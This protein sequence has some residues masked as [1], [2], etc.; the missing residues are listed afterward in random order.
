MNQIPLSD[1]IPKLSF[2][3]C[4]R[5]SEINYLEVCVGS[6]AA[7]R[8]IVEDYEKSFERKGI[9]HIRII[10]HF[11]NDFNIFALVS[12]VHERNLGDKIILKTRVTDPQV[13]RS[14]SNAMMLMF[15]WCDENFADGLDIDAVGITP[16]NI[17]DEALFKLRLPFLSDVI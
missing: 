15:E 2:I 17:E 10:P 8:S 6:P 7:S 13:L 14:F 3:S 11:S 16:R 4:L 12:D 1:I 5:V 9:T